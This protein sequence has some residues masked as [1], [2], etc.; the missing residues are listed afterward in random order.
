[1]GRWAL[2]LVTVLALGGVAVSQ[3]ARK[4]STADAAGLLTIDTLIDIKHP[5]DAMW[6]PDGT[7]V[8][9]IWDR[10]GVLNLYVEDVSG[11]RPS[12]P[13]ALTSYTDGELGNAFWSSDGRS[14]FLARTGDLWQVAASG[15][16][17][18][19]P[20]WK[21]ET[22]ESGI[23]LS[24]D[25]RQVAFSRG[26]DLWIRSLTDGS[27]KRVTTT[28]TPE[29]GPV[30][31]PDGR[32]L[33]FT[34]ATSTRRSFSPDYH[35]SKIQFL[36]S[37][38]VASPDVGI[39]SIADGK[40]VRAAVTDGAESGPKWIDNNQLVLNR[41]AKSYKERE[42]VVVDAATGEGK[43]V[44]RDVE[45]KWFNLTYNDS[46]PVP[47]PDG[48][49]IAFVSD[50][51]KWDHPYIVASSGGPAIQL[52]KGEHEDS[53]L[54]WSPDGRRLAFDT[55]QGGPQTRKHIAVVEIDASGQPRPA[56]A[57]TTGRGASTWP[58]WSPRGDRILYGHTDPQTSPEFFVVSAS[59]N[60]A[61]PVRLTESMP[62]AIDRSKLVEPRLV[63]YP[64]KDGK[65]VRANL[66]VPSTL[67][68][69]R[70]HPAIVWI[71]GDLVT[72][73]YDGWHIR[74]D[75]G[76]YYSF[77]QYLMQ[78]DGYVVLAPDYRGSIGY[79]KDW[80]LGVYRDLGGNDAF[81]VLAGVDYLKTLGYVDT[82]RVGVWGLSYGGFLTLRTIVV[83][84]TAF[85]AAVDVSGVT[86]WGDYMR[87][88]GQP[89]LE[90][91]MG[92]REDNP[93]QYEQGA[94]VRQV[95]QIVRPLLVLGST[96]D[97]NVPYEQTVRLVDRLLKAG[98][99]IEFM[100]YPGETHYFHREHVLRDAWRRVERFFNTHLQ[101]SATS[102][103]AS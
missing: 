48:K 94:P 57:L 27:E 53:R 12:E 69:S 81:D 58:I 60:V 3:V 22:T 92:T 16:Q 102:S 63:E 52:S 9:F 83:S 1:M 76:A 86:D 19:Q 23:E 34:T 103:P 46:G 56:I 32:R 5:S 77:H 72:E 71:H 21:S 47:S 50:R 73:N 8:A 89:W 51:D 45:D 54:A 14:I 25:G 4:T 85:R 35:G 68:R 88:P 74:R 65:P 70:K 90:A 79:G 98:K 40:T 13:V 61:S 97:T 84:P 95:S 2:G 26:G 36:W 33:A 80:R 66:F 100:M 42:I 49:W 41:I 43:V 38:R 29:S 91:R 99:D 37:E 20:V 39:V 30:W 31:S 17:A 24:P 67:D 18:P 64:S 101:P 6:S 78:H 75:Y 15:G 93:K 10:A 7:R 62:R 59:P 44:H 87:D 28:D 11:N 82:E 55:N 96:A